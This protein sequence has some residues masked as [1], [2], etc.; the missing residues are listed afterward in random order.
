MEGNER[1]R[2]NA[3]WGVTAGAE[4]GDGR[5]TGLGR[6]RSSGGKG[7]S[8]D[9]RVIAVVEGEQ[10]R[11]HGLESDGIS[12]GRGRTTARIGE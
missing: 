8:T 1:E 9:W 12:G 4:G 7:D 5:Q 3:D 6:D 10:R 11:Q 2:D